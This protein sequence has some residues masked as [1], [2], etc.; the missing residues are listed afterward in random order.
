MFK[1]RLV[2]F[3][4]SWFGFLREDVEVD[5]ERGGE[6]VRFFF[7]MNLKFIGFKVKFESLILSFLVE[8]D[9]RCFRVFLGF[10][11]GFVGI[12]LEKYIV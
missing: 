7:F 5:G 3:F 2:F 11:L 1:R 4:F 12:L 9:I 10:L 8:G 6:N